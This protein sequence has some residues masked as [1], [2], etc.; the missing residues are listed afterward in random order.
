MDRQEKSANTIRK[1]LISTIN[2]TT[3]IFK[4]THIQQKNEQRI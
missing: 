3:Q 4:K 2:S 1:W